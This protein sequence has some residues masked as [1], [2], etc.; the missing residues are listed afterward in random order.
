M[1]NIV[2]DKGIATLNRKMV[3][4]SLNV[5][6][7]FGK[8]SRARVCSQ[9]DSTLLDVTLCCGDYDNYMLIG[10]ILDMDLKQLFNSKAADRYRQIVAKKEYGKIACCSTCYSYI[11][12]N[13]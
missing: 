10:N 1:K 7:K 11:P 2:T 5:L 4:A 13:K 8:W 3:G 6:N 12:M 9:T